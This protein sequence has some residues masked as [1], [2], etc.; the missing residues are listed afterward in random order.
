[1]DEPC[2]FTRWR[3]GS[4]P[5][6]SVTVHSTLDGFSMLPSRGEREPAPRLAAIPKDKRPRVPAPLTRSP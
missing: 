3:G 6:F 1:M 5:G 2:G 4:V